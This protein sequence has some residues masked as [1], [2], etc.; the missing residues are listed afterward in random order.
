MWI[1]PK[2]KL[3]LIK[4]FER[5][6]QEEQKQINW[7]AKK[8]LSKINYKIHTQSIKKN[9]IPKILTKEQI[10]HVYAEEADVLNMALFGVTAGKWK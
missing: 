6:K 10:N 5:L 9:L 3:L 1:S 8:E 2:F 7:N 4:E